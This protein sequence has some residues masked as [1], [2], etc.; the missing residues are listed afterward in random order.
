MRRSL[1]SLIEHKI[2]GK[3]DESRPARA[4][5]FA[6]SRRNPGIFQDSSAFVAW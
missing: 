4:G 1:L 3:N 6:E 2:F 5:F